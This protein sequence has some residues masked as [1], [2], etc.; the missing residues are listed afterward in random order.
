MFE[1]DSAALDETP[2]SKEDSSLKE[3][4]KNRRLAINLLST[5]VAWTVS[6]FN[7]YLITFYLKYFRG[8]IYENSLVFAASDF[9]GYIVS[10]FVMKKTTTRWALVIGTSLSGAG[11]LMYMFLYRVVDLVPVMITFARVGNTMGFNV[12]YCANAR[13]FPTKFVATSF[14]IANFIARVLTIGAPLVAEIK[15]P[16]PFSVFLVLTGAA[17]FASLFLKEVN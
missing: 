10:G 1:D 14:G 6:S 17:I 16:W 5:I 4:F 12:I 9:V 2:V 8:N 11:G 3:L 13:L 7:F 15:D